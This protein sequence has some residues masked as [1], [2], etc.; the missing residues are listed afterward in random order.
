MMSGIRL[1][2]RLVRVDFQEA[3]GRFHRNS[4][5]LFMPLKAISSCLKPSLCQPARAPGHTGLRSYGEGLC[6]VAIH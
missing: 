6:A 2:Q 4:P 3:R 5:P 1:A